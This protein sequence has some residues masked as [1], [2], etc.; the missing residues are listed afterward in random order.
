VRA[1]FNPTHFS[2]L[3]P[4]LM[5]LDDEAAALR[6]LQAHPPRW[7]FYN[8]APPEAYLKHWPS[9]DPSRLRLN[10]IERF[11]SSNY[12]SVERLSHRLGDFSLLERVSSE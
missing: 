10:S 3:Q 9:S 12:R 8:D 5:T 4:E 7:V 11:L 6:E 1:T 2:Y